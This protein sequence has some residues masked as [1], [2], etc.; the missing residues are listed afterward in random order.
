MAI[1]RNKLRR[2][3]AACYFGLVGF[4]VLAACLSYGQTKNTCLDCHS[5]L[6]D[7]LG[8]SQEK[9]SQDIHSQKGLTC[10]SCHGGDPSSDDPDKAMSRKAGWKGKIDHKQ[11]PQ[12]CGSCHSDPA[13]IRQ[14][15]PSLRTD[16]FLGRNHFI[17]SNLEMNQASISE[18]CGDCNVGGVTA[19]GHQHAPDAG[20]I[21][22]RIESP[23]AAF[24]VHL[25]PGAEV[26]GGVGER[27]RDV[28]QISSRVARWNI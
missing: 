4:V 19:R 22:P 27:N 5:A 16:P 13:Y 7:P 23:P 6:P 26:H 11:V 24:E 3:S 8:V 9:F 14:F 1:L 15:N 25:E 17:G 28:S 21:I 2:F 20:D 12:L 10:A 18:R